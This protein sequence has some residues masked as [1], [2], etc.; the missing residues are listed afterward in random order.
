VMRAESA[1]LSAYV[2]EHKDAVAVSSVAVT[3]DEFARSALGAAR[4]RGPLAIAADG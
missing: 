4:G 3:A 2:N 1:E